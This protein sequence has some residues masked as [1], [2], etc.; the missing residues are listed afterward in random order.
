M[1]KIAINNFLE[2]KI[3]EEIGKNINKE[4]DNVI[5]NNIKYKRTKKIKFNRL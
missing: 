2:Y 5:D 1:R 3:K 4:F